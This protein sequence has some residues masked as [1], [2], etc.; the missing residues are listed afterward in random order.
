MLNNKATLIVINSNIEYIFTKSRND[1]LDLVSYE[2]SDLDNT[3]FAL[4]MPRMPQSLNFPPSPNTRDL[5]IV[6]MM[7]MTITITVNIYY[8]QC[9]KYCA[10]HFTC[11]IRIKTH[12]NL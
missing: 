6:T 12:N 2:L 8:F 5:I 9:T 7:M 11:I 10:K 3:S 4:Q 1:R